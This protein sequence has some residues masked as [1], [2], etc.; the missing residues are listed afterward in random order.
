MKF[1][2]K[3]MDP[4]YLVVHVGNNECAC[5]D[6]GG[7]KIKCLEAL[8]GVRGCKFACGNVYRVIIY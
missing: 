2:L 4:M 8:K 1:N 6:D 3:K 5:H 7:V